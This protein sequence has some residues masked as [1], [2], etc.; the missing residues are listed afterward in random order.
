M[1]CTRVLSTFSHAQP[2]VRLTDLSWSLNQRQPLIQLLSMSPKLKPT[3]RTFQSAVS[4]QKNI[5]HIMRCGASS[6][7]CPSLQHFPP[8]LKSCLRKNIGSTSRKHVI[9]VDEMGLPLTAVHHFTPDPTPPA[10]ILEMGP[11]LTQAES[12]QPPSNRPPRHKFVLGF[13]QPTQ[14]INTFFMRLKEKQ[15]LLESCCIS[16]NTLSGKVCVFH[17]S[18]QQAVHIS[19]TCDSWRSYQD[20][21]CTFLQHNRFSGIDISIFPFDI[22]LPQNI[23][24]KDRIEFGISFR[25]GPAS[26]PVWDDN[27][28]QK[29]RVCIEADDLSAG[30]GKANGYHPTLPRPRSPAR[31]QE[32]AGITDHADLQY[33]SSSVLSLT[34]SRGC[35]SLSRPLAGEGRGHPE[36]VTNLSQGHTHSRGKFRVAN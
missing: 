36:Q 34:G 29:Y 24:P 18:S 26:T 13:P 23:D 16:E 8:R 17:L 5:Y 6:P 20:F 7:T 1:A 32:A 21:P 14:D 28:T 15:V 31:P 30:Q 9:F 10:S 27:R 22:K 35:R 33:S 11:S 19:L 4:P 3:Q 25:A 12:Q 2:P